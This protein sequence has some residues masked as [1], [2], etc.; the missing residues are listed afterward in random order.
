MRVIAGS[1]RGRVFKAPR[2]AA[3]RPTSDRVRE[4]LFSIIGDVGG[5]QVIDLYAGTGALGIEALS[6]GAEHA[7]FVDHARQAITV[8]RGN[9]RDL[10]IE[11]R[12]TVLPVR[13]ER[14]VSAPLL[15]GDGFDLVLA[16]PPYRALCD[17]KVLEALAALLGGDAST[18][19]RRGGKVVL[20]HSKSLLPPAFPGLLH[21]DLRIYGDTAL[22][23]YRRCPVA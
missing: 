18:V 15:R 20:E 13:V 2:G 7:T 9:V 17:A 1:L 21:E 12:C 8:L 6:R 22:S 3:T 4:A 19:V 23:F 11:Q 5:M 14:L 16:D 10:G